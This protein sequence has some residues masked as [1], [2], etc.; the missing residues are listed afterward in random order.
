MISSEPKDGDT[1][2]VILMQN[3]DNLL[4]R[5]ECGSWS[6]L[7]VM[8]KDGGKQLRCLKCLAY[9]RVFI[10]AHPKDEKGEFK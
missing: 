9:I 6:W 2:S 10:L 1:A 8:D 5:C 3:K 7:I 4:F